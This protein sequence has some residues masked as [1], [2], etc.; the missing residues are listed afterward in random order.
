MRVYSICGS[1]NFAFT[2]VYFCFILPAVMVPSR[3]PRISFQLLDSERVALGAATKSAG[4]GIVTTSPRTAASKLNTNWL[5]SRASDQL[6]T[7]AL[8]LLLVW[9]NSGRDL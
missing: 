1:S 9:V 7:P 2:L 6:V 8:E 5:G 3:V 4:V